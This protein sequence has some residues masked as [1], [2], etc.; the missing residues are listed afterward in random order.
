[1]IKYPP[2]GLNY[3]RIIIISAIL[4]IGITYGFTTFRVLSDPVQRTGSDFLAF[5]TA[6]NIARQAGISQI[7]NLDLQRAVE[8]TQVNFTLSDQQILI[9][10]HPPFLVPIMSVVM[11]NDYVNSFIIWILLLLILYTL[12]MY[13]LQK[14]LPD[15]DPNFTRIIIASAV[16]FQPVYISEINGQDTV[17]LLLGLSFFLYKMSRGQESAAGLALGLLTLRPQMI[18]F[19]TIPLLFWSPKAFRSFMLASLLLTMISVF[20]LGKQGTLEFIQ[21]LQTS[22]IGEWFGMNESGMLNLLGFAIRLQTQ[23]SIETLRIGTWLLFL[24]SIILVALFSKLSKLESITKF[25]IAMIIFLFT[26]PHL[27]YHDLSLLLIPAFIIIQKFS[28]P[29]IV[30]MK[31]LSL[32]VTITSFLAFCSN[33]LPILYYSFPYLLM[34]AFLFLLIRNKHPKLI[35]IS[36]INFAIGN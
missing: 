31:R 2:R 11:G 35:V 20:M 5:F 34:S 13:L 32:Y 17:F 29:N 16:L 23:L 10:N 30:H 6:G 36:P 24:T 7:Y 14:I 22:R 26:T 21:L 4:A 8:Q 19:F 27:H 1:M 12:C 15:M 28:S 25:G 9:Y 33:F 18:L 3:Q